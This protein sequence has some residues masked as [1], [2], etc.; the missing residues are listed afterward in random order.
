MKHSE[1]EEMGE[2]S[3]LCHVEL[4]A[5]GLNLTNK[6]FIIWLSP[7]S[8]EWIVFEVLLKQMGVVRENSFMGE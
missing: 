7:K 2:G 6:N 1:G 5:S 3:S 8:T 4:T